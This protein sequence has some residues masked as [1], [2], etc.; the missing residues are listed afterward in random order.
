MKYDAIAMYADDG[1][2][3]AYINKERA[4]W[5]L[6]RDLAEKGE[7]FI[8]IKF[9]PKGPGS[10]SKIPKK[11]ICVIDG[12]SSNDLTSHHVVPWCYKQHFPLK[13]K[14]Y[15][16]HDLV[17]MCRKHHGQY[18]VIA[19]KYKLELAKEWLPLF[20]NYY[21]TGSYINILCKHAS[22]LPGH[23]RVQMWE[24][25]AKYQCG[26]EYGYYKSIY[27]YTLDKLGVYRIMV[28]FRE[29]FVKTMNPKFLPEDYEIY[30]DPS[31]RTIRYE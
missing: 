29:H 12:E 26:S 9:K 22:K 28:L 25:I 18:E 11:N 23:I 17:L 19:N 21:K 7:G 5:Y 24:H 30:L 13:Y 8:K 10:F 2:L 31:T 20:R 16:S 6:D 1:S 14:G 4:S 27:E 15:T 3:L